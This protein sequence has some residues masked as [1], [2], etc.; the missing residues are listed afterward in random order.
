MRTTSLHVR[1]TDVSII[2][3]GIADPNLIETPRGSVV[4]GPRSADVLRAKADVVGCPCT[5]SGGVWS[6]GVIRREGAGRSGRAR[7]QEVDAVHHTTPCIRLHHTT[8]YTVDGGA[9]D[10]DASYYTTHLE[11][12]RLKH[13][14]CQWDCKSDFCEPYL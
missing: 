9:Y 11:S 6:G 10:R 8:E 7:C 3:V 4:G 1:H 2:S 14:Q 12:I 13:T 5:G